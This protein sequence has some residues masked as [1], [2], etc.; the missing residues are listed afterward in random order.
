MKALRWIACIA[1]GV[2]FLSLAIG[3]VL[4]LTGPAEDIRQVWEVL[5]GSE[6]TFIGVQGESQSIRMTDVQKVRLDMGAAAV[7]I[8]RHDGDE[9]EISYTTSGLGVNRRVLAECVD[10]TLTIRTEENIA[11]SFWNWQRLRVTIALPAAYAGKLDVDMTAGTLLLEEKQRFSATKLRMGAGTLRIEELDTD[12]LDADMDAG[13]LVI[14]KLSSTSYTLTVD[15][16]SATLDEATGAG[17]VTVNAG[18]AR[19]TCAQLTDTMRLRVSAGSLRLRLPEDAAAT[20]SLKAS[21][22][23]VRQEFGARF[24]GVDSNNRI[25]GT[26]KGGGALISGDVSAGSLR[27]ER[28]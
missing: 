2:F 26:V 4:L 13:Q 22:G 8:V 25:E 9:A 5:R 28:D 6:Q 14:D 10:D 21:A 23:S 27:I 1:G 20:L 3:V 15:A 12:T 11:W 7:S 24:S 19:V 17:E 16:G 18:S